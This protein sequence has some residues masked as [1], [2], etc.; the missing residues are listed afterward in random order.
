MEGYNVQVYKFQQQVKAYNDAVKALEV[1]KTLADKFDGKVINKRFVTALNEASNKFFGK[2]NVVFSLCQEG[3]NYSHKQNI[4][5]IELYLTDRCKCYEGGCIYIGNDRVRVYEVSTDS[6]CYINSDG[7]LN[8]E[9][10][11]K[12]LD[13]QINNCKEAISKYQLC[14]DHFDEYL[15][16]VK[17]FNKKLDEL[18][19]EI[20]YPMG[21]STFKLELPFW[22]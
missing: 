5:Q 21:I 11:I 13:K 2:S 1:A 9:I 16:K 12:A 3:Y 19:K 6:D 20:P 17:D 10:F 14:I 15:D 22:Y 18:R 4:V 7:R 8:K